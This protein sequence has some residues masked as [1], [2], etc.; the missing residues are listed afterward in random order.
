[1]YR[2]LIELSL[3]CPGGAG[4]SRAGLCMSN[5]IAVYDY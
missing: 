2:V 4:S 1:M 3:R 5:C